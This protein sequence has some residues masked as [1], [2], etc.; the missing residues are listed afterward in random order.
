METPINEFQNEPAQQKKKKGRTGLVIFLLL[1]LLAVAGGGAYYYL[2]RQQ[3]QKTVDSYLKAIQKMDIAAMETLL[4]SQDVSAL[5]TVELRSDMYTEFFK[6][7]NS[8]MTYEITKNAYHFQE[9]TAEV[10]AKIQYVDGTN[11]FM[12]TISEFLRQIVSSAFSGESLSEEETQQKLASILTETAKTVDGE[13]T[14]TTI[15]YPVVK[16]DSGWKIAA[17]DA[18]TVKF[19]SANFSGVEDEI[20]AS[21][22]QMAAGADAAAPEAAGTS[23][24]MNNEK[25]SIRYTQHRTAKDINGSPCL[26]LYYDYTNNSSTPSSAMVDVSIQAY[27]DGVLCDAAIPEAHDEAV[28][29]FMQEVQP[30]QTVNVCQV[31]SLGSTTDVTL[32]ATDTFNFD[33]DTTSQVLTLQ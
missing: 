17:L 15:T 14:E 10:T 11:I 19:M 24:D 2:Q 28:D 21:L 26:M 33:G 3:P 32:Q 12:E 23:I 30:G 13:M 29:R 6:S 20:N 9:G 25:F 22:E 4:Q 31:F 8:R 18:E 1:L 7:M 16:T 5:D 27:Q